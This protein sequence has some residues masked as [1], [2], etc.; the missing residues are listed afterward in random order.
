MEMFVSSK[1][2]VFFEELLKPDFTVLEYGSGGSTILLQNKVKKLYSIEH[3]PSWYDKVKSLLNNNTELY[4]VQPNKHYIEGGHDGT[5]E[6]FQDYVN[7]GLEFG[8]YDLVFVDGRARVSCCRII[9]AKLKKT[10]IVVIHDFE[11]NEYKSVLN[12]FNLIKSLER[13]AVLKPK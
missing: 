3:Q 12:E 5:Y 13:M 11:R 1:E 8:P 4:L 2:K 9:K 7:K 6:E 10:G